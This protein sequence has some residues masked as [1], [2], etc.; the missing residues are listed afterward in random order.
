MFTDMVGSTKLAQTNEPEALRLRDEQEELVRPLFAA[1]QGREIKSIGDGFLAEFDSALRAL[2]CAIDIQQR[3]RERNAQ[4]GVT[5]LRLRIGIHLGDVEV[6]A[7]DI[8]GDSVNIASRIEPLAEPGGICISEPV[9][10]QVR[11]KVPNKLEKLP[12]TS[13]KGVQVPIEIYRV[14]LPEPTPESAA[15]DIPITG[16]AVLPFTNIS[17]DPKDEYFAEGLT[18]ELITM[19]SQVQELRVISRTSVTR[20]KASTKS[21]SE[22]GTELGVSSIL[23]GSVRKA[24]NR[25]RIAA[26]LIDAQSDRHLWA[27]TFDRELNDIFEVQA[28]IATQVAAEL[29]VALRPTEKARIEG[30][31]PVKTES[32]L[33]YLKGR[34]D[35]RI[36]TRPSL[37]AAKAQFERA[38]ALD[39]TNAAAHARLADVTRILGHHFTGAPANWEET[40]SLHAARALE[41]DPNLAEAH[42]T[43]AA[44]LM[45]YFDY[46]GAEREF[47]AAI[48]L[49]PSDSLTHLQYAICLEAEG[50][51]DAA[52]QERALAELVDPLW[53]MNLAYSVWVLIMLR[54]FDEALVKIQKL[55]E[56]YPDGP[57][58]H[59][60][61]ADYYLAQSDLERGLSEIRRVEELEPDPSEKWHIR[62]WY[63][64][65]AGKREEART[66]LRGRE[67]T[68]ETV[69]TANNLANRYAELGDLDDCF[70][71]CERAIELH[72]FQASYLL[73]EPRLEH[74]RKDPRF[75]ALLKRI[76]LA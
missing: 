76:N 6:R 64:T 49:N 11:N 72:A 50:R 47:K 61:L 43:L 48:S 13:L 71:L 70:R 30:R 67:T 24:G 45:D 25:L 21:V 22:I 65:A 63:L 32:Y 14:V 60:A 44:K 28:E 75:L 38:L 53:S 74:V 42:G 7:T 18:E 3:L 2:Q 57:S 36:R 34:S 23:E 19:L 15:T 41:L 35:L 46:A 40:R 62:V 55:G 31:P 51:G 12:S 29:Q 4:A 56:L 16:I 1:H 5:P 68:P 66:I 73:L 17:P 33:A 8:F 37:E 52:L 59:S 27:K 10:G 54:R 69:F 58:Y 20:Y 9:F 39:E 26:Q